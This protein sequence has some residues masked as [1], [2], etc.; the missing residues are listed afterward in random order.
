MILHPDRP[1]QSPDSA[2]SELSATTPAGKWAARLTW[3]A[4]WLAA[5]G[6]LV[7]GRTM[8]LDRGD[9][10]MQLR[11]GLPT[12]SFTERTGLPCPG[13][14]VTTSFAL[15]L[16]ADLASAARVHGAGP[17]LALICVVV[18]MYTPYAVAHA[19]APARVLRTRAAYLLGFA[20]LMAWAATYLA[21][22]IQFLAP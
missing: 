20:L 11:L 18:A 12:C 3:I 4:T 1:A 14:G 6:A 8:H 2:G 19:H 16:H 22:F 17:L 15:T 13:C 10:G 9:I 5:C 7:L 21:R